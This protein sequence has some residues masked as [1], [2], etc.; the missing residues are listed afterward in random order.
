VFK[1]HNPNLEGYDYWDVIAASTTKENGF[2]GPV[3]WS[4]HLWFLTALFAHAC[5]SGP[6]IWIFSAIQRLRLSK[7]FGLLPGR[8]VLSCLAVTVAVLVVAGRAF[9]LATFGRVG[10]SSWIIQSVFAYA[11]FYALGLY[12]HLEPSVRNKAESFD[13]FSFIVL[14]V[15]IAI[16]FLIPDGGIG[17]QI[18]DI[19]TQNIIVS[20]S[21]F[22]L[23][24]VF[25]T[26][27]AKQNSIMRKLS[28]A[29]Y[30]M[31]LLHYVVIY[32]IAF[33]CMNTMGIRGVGVYIVVAVVTPVTTFLIHEKVIAKSKAL[34]FMLNGRRV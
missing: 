19:V 10:L 29:I 22:L 16:R 33:I 31:Y 34:S 27:M 11:P 21:C 14:I 13:T 20:C 8:L 26:W 7:L 6:L 1:V 30:S 3:I 24:H 9:F 15:G 32:I 12:M 17:W 28:R 25:A 18:V 5:F 23:F 4:Q 2:N